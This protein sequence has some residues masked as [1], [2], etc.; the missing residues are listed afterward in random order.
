MDIIVFLY[1]IFL[2]SQQLAEVLPVRGL[3]DVSAPS[4]G[5]QNILTLVLGEHTETPNFALDA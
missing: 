3:L 1:S 5:L 4:R 2:N